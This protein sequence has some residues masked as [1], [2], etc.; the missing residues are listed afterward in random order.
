MLVLD[1]N[2][3][4]GSHRVFEAPLP[5]SIGRAADCD[6]RLKAWR[7]GRYHAT[8]ERRNAGT[9]IDDQGTLGGT[10]VN[11]RRITQYGPLTTTDEIIIGPCLIRLKDCYGSPSASAGKTDDGSGAPAS[12]LQVSEAPVFL[13]EHS[14]TGVTGLYHSHALSMAHGGVH[15]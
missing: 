13:A 11:G 12:P 14:T 8:I 6:L 3:E 5:V 1:L 2:F 4:D 15:A 9:F 10:F 7:V